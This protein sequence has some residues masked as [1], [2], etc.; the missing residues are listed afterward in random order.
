MADISR[1]E[2]QFVSMFVIESKRERYLTKLKG[3]KHRKQILDLLNHSLDYHGKKGH[4]QRI[5]FVLRFG[6]LW[7]LN[8]LLFGEN[9]P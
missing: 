4:A 1:W 7:W 2:Q 3:R 6:K 8:Q 9:L 5:V